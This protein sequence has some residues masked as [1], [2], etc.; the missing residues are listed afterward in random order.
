M[1]YQ[2]SE[3]CGLYYENIICSHN[4]MRVY[5]FSSPTFSTNHRHFCPGR[6]HFSLPPFLFYNIA[7]EPLPYWEQPMSVSTNKKQPSHPAFDRLT[8]MIMSGMTKRG[9][10][11][12]SQ[13]Y[14]LWRTWCARRQ[15]DPLNL[16][17]TTLTNFLL[18][19]KVTYN[20]RRR[21][22]SA[23]R[24]LAQAA[25]EDD[26][27]DVERQKSYAQLLH[28]RVPQR[29]LIESTYKTHELNA[30]QADSVLDVWQGEKPIQRR[31][32]A[33]VALLFMTGLRRSELNRLERLHCDLDD[34]T[35]YVPNDERTEL[36]RTVAIP[37]DAALDALRDWVATLPPDRVYL[38]PKIH[39]S[40]LL[41]PDR[42]MSDQAVYSVIRQTEQL[43]G[44]KFTPQ[45]ARRTFLAE[46]LN[47]GSPVSDVQIQAGHKDVLSTLK[48]AK[49]PEAK[50]RRERLKLGYGG[51]R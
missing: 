46:A 24:R 39:Y 12:Y 32:R 23:L 45:D 5:F 27:D 29:G 43:S 18:T 2:F 19:Q 14:A 3:G 34:G 26:P 49:S 33:L 35:L 47:N 30:H 15:I 36:S 4:Y 25:V 50:K 9:S 10:R 44:L 6:K 13:T 41:G 11:S 7:K 1:G 38:F 48:Y 16:Q 51:K 28:L 37:G 21:H 8:S 40:G 31:N 42:P 17:K 20:T 22:L